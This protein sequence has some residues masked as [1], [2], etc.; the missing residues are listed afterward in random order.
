M[1]AKF[2]FG[3]RP[4]AIWIHALAYTAVL[5]LMTMGCGGGGGGG[6]GGQ[7]TPSLT[8]TGASTPAEIT[9][10][11]AK[12]IAAG[13][14]D[15]GSSG[16]TFTGIAALDSTGQT[17]DEPNLLFL[18]D[19]TK[20]LQGAMAGIDFVEAAN[21]GNMS[22]A[23][24]PESGSIVGTCGGS[25]SYSIQVDDVSGVFSG[26]L[27][28]NG[29]CQDGVILNGSTSFSGIANL[30]TNP[31][32]LDSFTLSFDYITAA[33]GSES[34]TMDGDI[35][36]VVSGSTTMVTMDLMLRDNSTRRICKVENYQMDITDHSSYVE[37]EVGGLYYD[38]DYGYVDLQTTSPF[39]VN[40]V[41]NYP[42]SGQLLLT[43][44]NGTAGGPTSARL[45][46]LSS[47]TC[48]VEADTDGDGT[49]TGLDDYDSGVILWTEL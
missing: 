2:R 9:A 35:D 23:L 31:I 45:T 20:A 30:N 44:E 38:P 10:N 3:S 15:A 8:Y 32:E 27:T 28:F 46:A 37:I 33:S 6:G 34:A 47:T 12:G 17:A 1:I 26:S 7:A 39:L 19:V 25:A 36:I 40:N 13:A 22:S 42:Y 29:Y 4:V 16:I 21:Q 49:Y 41:D 5:C 24:Q 43:G 18:V 11:N 48:R 14:L